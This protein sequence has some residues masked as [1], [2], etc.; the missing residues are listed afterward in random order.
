MGF[1][2]AKGHPFFEG[3]D[4]NSMEKNKIKPPPLNGKL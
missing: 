4:W 3:I 2:R 1:N